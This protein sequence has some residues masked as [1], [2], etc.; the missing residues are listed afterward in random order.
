MKNIKLDPISE[1]NIAARLR[2][3]MINRT[4]TEMT[5]AVKKALNDPDPNCVAKVVDLNTKLKTLLALNPAH[6]GEVLMRYLDFIEAVDAVE[7]DNYA[8]V[9]SVCLRMVRDIAFTFAEHSYPVIPLE[10]SKVTP[11][12]N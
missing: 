9:L 12:T 10:D 5:D 11:V 2:Q 1:E 6:Y 7:M 8:G 3:L 4:L